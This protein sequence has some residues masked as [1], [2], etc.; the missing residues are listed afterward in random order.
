MRTTIRGAA[1]ALV[2]L[3]AVLA[4]F[5]GAAS[6]Q[7]AAPNCPP[8]QPSGRPP[9]APPDS[10]PGNPGRPAY[11]PGRCQLAL[12]QSSAARGDSFRASGG[13]FAPGED[14][15]LS[16]AGMNVRSVAAD[17]N[18]AFAADLTVPDD[19]PV[20]RT[21]VRATGA[22]QTLAAAF[23]V[24]APAAAARS[25]AP[26]ASFLPRTGSEFVAT[27]A[28]GAVLLALG[29]VLVLSARRTRSVVV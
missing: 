17:A 11:P 3:T 2:A 9:G 22:N 7:A 27:A 5:A 8:G 29:A 24:L 21:E 12:S 26:E 25:R 6:G 28:L 10:P 20:G 18:G 16:I 4:L 14:V 1:L 23:E 15:T 19:A 13:G